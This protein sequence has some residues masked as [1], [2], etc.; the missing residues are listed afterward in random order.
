MFDASG[1]DTN[2]CP[3]TEPREICG[4][5][6]GS[7][8]TVTVTARDADANTASTD[9]DTLT[10]SVSVT[11][12]VTLASN[13]SPLTEANLNGAALTVTLPSGT[14]FSS[15]VSAS[16]F[17]LVTSPTLAGLSINNVTGGASGTRTATLT[18]ATGTGYGFS[19]PATL[20]VRVLA[21]AHSGSTALTS[22]ALPVSPTP[23]ITLSRESLTLQEDPTFGGGTNQNRGTYTIVPDSPPTGCAGIGFAPAS[24]NA[25]VAVSPANHQFNNSNWTTP[26][27]FTVTAAQD[28]DNIHDVATISHSVIINCNAAGYPTSLTLPSLTVNV[29]DETSRR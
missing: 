16:G 7:G 20:A 10:F 18:L 11:S 22:A 25:D 19:T 14:T 29:N 1:T 3:G 21:A 12:G 15:G 26:K 4:T 28:G 2:G 24:D 9:E 6:T 17:A 8:G 27:T 13:P 23:G 5:P